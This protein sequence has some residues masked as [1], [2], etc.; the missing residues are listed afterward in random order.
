M[1]SSTVRSGGRSEIAIPVLD[2]PFRDVLFTL[3]AIFVSRRCLCDDPSGV[4]SWG[5]QCEQFTCFNSSLPCTIPSSL[6]VWY[7]FMSLFSLR[8]LYKMTS[9]TTNNRRCLGQDKRRTPPPRGRYQGV[10]HSDI[11]A[12]PRSKLVLPLL[13]ISTSPLRAEI[14]Q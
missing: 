10:V 1:S 13:S 11:P 9:A 6:V 12:A 8:L 4:D 2:C 3:I 14:G 5:T 7:S